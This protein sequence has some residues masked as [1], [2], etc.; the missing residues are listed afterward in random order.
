MKNDANAI[1]SIALFT[2]AAFIACLL[3]AAFSIYAHRPQEV[4]TVYEKKYVYVDAYAT[5]N[6]NAGEIS[7]EGEVSWTVKEYFGKIG[8]FTDD[9]KLIKTLEVY[10]KTLPKTDRDLLREGIVVTS[11]E[12]LESLIEDYTG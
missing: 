5:E 4:K 7:E 8:I 12:A 10:T 11:Y 2:T 9:G 1:T 3:F 6:T